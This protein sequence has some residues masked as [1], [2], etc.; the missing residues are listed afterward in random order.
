M[1]SI[2]VPWII[3]QRFTTDTKIKQ[4][5]QHK[6][7][8]AYKFNVIEHLKIL[9]LKLSPAPDTQKYSDCKVEIGI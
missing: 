9:S 3:T 2:H 5:D 6:N 1:L 7:Q 4:D 8:E